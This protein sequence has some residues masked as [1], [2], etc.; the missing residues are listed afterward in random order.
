MIKFTINKKNYII[1]N[2]KIKDL[3]FILDVMKYEE[4]TAGIK[5]ISKLSGA[6]ESEVAKLQPFQFNPLFSL[7][8]EKVK[9]NSDYPLKRTIE[10]NGKKYGF[11]HLE[12]LTIGELADLEIIKADPQPDLLTHQILSILYRPI[13]KQ[14]GEEYDLVEYNGQD[15]LK[16]SVDFLEMDIEVMYGAIFFLTTFT[17][18]S[19]DYIVKH[20]EETMETAATQGELDIQNKK[21]FSIGLKSFIQSLRETHL[22]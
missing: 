7:I 16:R 8:A 19:T 6:P 5:I 11:I 4:K 20:L 1:P 21:L 18:I 10:L 9:L 22:N 14:K 13:V 12:K 2:I 17:K 3:Y 15:C